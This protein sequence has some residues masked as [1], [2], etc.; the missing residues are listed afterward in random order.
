MKMSIQIKK[1]FV[2]SEDGTGGIIS[3]GPVAI[4]LDRANLFA[5]INAVKDVEGRRRIQVEPIAVASNSA[6][7]GT[8]WEVVAYLVE[9]DCYTFRLRGVVW[10][11]SVSEVLAS[12]ADLER[13]LDRLA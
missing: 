3:V 5:F 10:E 11:A 1:L 13:W 2:A 6:V 4:A 12:V 8:S 7:A 9:R